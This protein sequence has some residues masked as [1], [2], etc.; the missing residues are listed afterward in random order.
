MLEAP[1]LTELRQA[2]ALILK[3]TSPSD[4]ELDTIINQPDPLATYERDIAKVRAQAAATHHSSF[5]SIKPARYQDRR[6]MRD[7]V[8][9]ANKSSSTLPLSTHRLSSSAFKSSTTLP[10]SDLKSDVLIQ[11]SS[12]PASTRSKQK[13]MKVKEDV[14][15]ASIRDAMNARPKTSAAAC[16]DYRAPSGDSSSSSTRSNTTLDYRVST[17]MTSFAQTPAEEKRISSQFPPRTSSRNDSTSQTW[18]KQEL[19]QKTR[20]R[21]LA[22]SNPDYSVPTLHHQ[23]PPSRQSVRQYSRSRSRASSIK[24]NIIGGIRDYMQP[25]PSVEQSNGQSR[26]ESRSSSRPGSRASSVASASRSWL[27]SAAGGLRRKG[28]WSS[29]RSNRIEDDERERGRGRDKGPDLNRSLPPLPGLDQY[30][31]PK[32]HIA[33]LMA[34]PAPS[35]P[36]VASSMSTRDD[37]RSPAQHTRGSDGELPHPNDLVRPR[38]RIPFS[39]G[40]NDSNS[41]HSDRVNRALPASERRRR[42]KEMR[43]KAQDKARK[44]DADKGKHNQYNQSLDGN[45]ISRG[46]GYAKRQERELRRAVRDRVAQGSFS[47]E[48]KREKGDDE[49]SRM[50]RAKSKGS[51]AYDQSEGNVRDYALTGDTGQEWRRRLEREAARGGTPGSDK[52]KQHERSRAD[53]ERQKREKRWEQVQVSA[54]SEGPKRTLKNRI[55]RFLGGSGG[56]THALSN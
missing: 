11:A 34:H 39:D 22:T 33:Q 12:L 31:P 19:I 28:S 29:F 5:P 52:Q 36:R 44:N 21:D 26:A 32:V 6:S 47:K 51:Q 48:E 13:P 2:C 18:T 43:H 45:G 9:S 55:S 37:A 4:T 54:E 46:E 50:A 15:L 10:P 24:E 23:R 16:V 20:E 27:R 8:A 40:Y 1:V 53:K 42:E 14:S 3:E 49:F 56:A 7:G 38:P 41:D 35:P 25:R 30:K 17:G